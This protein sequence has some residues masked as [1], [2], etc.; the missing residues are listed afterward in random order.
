MKTRAGLVFFAVF[1]LL[2][3][4]AAEASSQEGPYTL[5]IKGTMGQITKFAVDM[6]GSLAFDLEGLPVPGATMKAENLAAGLTLDAYFDTKD[7]TEEGAT[8]VVK[9]TIKNIILGGLLQL[10]DM[11]GVG[12]GPAPELQMEI[13]PNGGINDIEVHNLQMPGAM[14]NMMKGA[15]PG[16][17]GM[18]MDFSSLDAILPI[19]V[20]LIPPIFPDEPI[21]VG[22]TWVRKI[23][24][25]DM[26]MPI[27]PIF[28]FNY[29]LVSV[30][31]GVAHIE[32]TTVGEYDAGFINSF[33]S[34]LPEIPMGSDVMTIDGLD[35]KM[36][37]DIAGTI[38]LQ[39]EKGLIENLNAK[40][41]I[42]IKGGGKITFTHPDGNSD[43]WEPKLIVGVDLTG[44]MKYD[45][46]VS[47]AEFNQ[48]FPPPEEEK[49]ADKGAGKKSGIG[50][51]GS[52]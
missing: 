50:K 7:V 47:R 8:F 38:D 2:A 44:G 43:K 11:G 32:Y 14:G 20:G 45:S 37:W 35:L 3:G 46:N 18:G 29:K 16:M 31:N 40:G 36:K 12:K 25:D 23:S 34:M 21:M 33:L 17:D 22:D 10:P 24:Q 30:E 4:F 51:K 1:A 5:K 26:P 42:A 27:F 6:G 52:E 48:L 39:I 13:A 9:G 19:I 41:K 15:V 49:P 28:E